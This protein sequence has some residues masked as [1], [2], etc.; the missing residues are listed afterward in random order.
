[1]RALGY[2]D[3]GVAAV[4]LDKQSPNAESVLLSPKQSHQVRIGCTLPFR[5]LLRKDGKL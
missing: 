4:T 5:K 3:L 1:M 2:S